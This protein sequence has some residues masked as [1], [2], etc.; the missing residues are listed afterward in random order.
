MA[1]YVA[2]APVVS[3]FDGLSL[4]Q[5]DDN[6]VGVEGGYSA[7][8]PPPPPPPPFAPSMSA[9]SNAGSEIVHSTA[10]EGQ[11]AAGPPPPPPPPP[12][13]LGT[14]PTYKQQVK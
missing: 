4:N 13:G 10:S 6:S 3:G 7:G 1:T 2:D 11:I 8:P 5:F 12:P 14:M 9:G